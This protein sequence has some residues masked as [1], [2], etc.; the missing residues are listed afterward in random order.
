MPLNFPESIDDL[1]ISQVQLMESVHLFTDNVKQAEIKRQDFDVRPSSWHVDTTNEG[2]I[3]LIR[4]N[5][6]TRFHAFGTDFDPDSVSEIEAFAFEGLKKWLSEFYPDYYAIEFKNNSQYEDL[7]KL[8]APDGNL[9]M[10]IPDG[11]INETSLYS[12]ISD[13]LNMLG[14]DSLKKEGLIEPYA[15]DF[16]EPNDQF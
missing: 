14:I 2:G 8:I 9:E 11:E 12:T 4:A 16:Y 6:S 13:V 3:Q 7:L 1:S 5:E 15:E 10:L